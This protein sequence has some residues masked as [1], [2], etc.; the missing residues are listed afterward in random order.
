MRS[1]EA[2]VRSRASSSNLRAWLSSAS[3]LGTGCGDT[4]HQRKAVGP[5]AA[6]QRVDG[7]ETRAYSVR[8]ECTI[9]A[10]TIQAAWVM[11]DLA[12]QVRGP[13]QGAPDELGG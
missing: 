3:L 10:I 12:T 2:P 7:R 11:T 5:M 8:F 13:L 9:G 6:S 1:T 4:G